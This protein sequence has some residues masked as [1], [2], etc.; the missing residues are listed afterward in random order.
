MK[1]NSNHERSREKVAERKY[2]GYKDRRPLLKSENWRVHFARS[3]E[4]GQWLP[5]LQAMSRLL[6]SACL[7]P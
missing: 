1:L 5:S 7:N 3:N 4:I 6:L 2:V